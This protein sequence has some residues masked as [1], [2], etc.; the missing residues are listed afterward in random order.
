MIIID[1]CHRGGAKDDGNWA[2]ILK[3]FSSAVQL[4]MTATPKR[5]DNIDTYA[6]FGEAVYEYSLKEGINDGFLTPYKVKRI[7]TNMDELVIDQDVQIVDGEVKKDI[8]GIKD[9]DKNIVVPERTEF[10]GEQILKL[11]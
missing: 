1:E 10:I 7:R 2:E 9:F 8:Y 11:I 5:K 6:Y 3:Y 4:G